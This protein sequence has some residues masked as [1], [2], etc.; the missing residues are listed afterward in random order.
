MTR[1]LCMP[2]VA[3]TVISPQILGAVES[4]IVNNQY[5]MIQIGFNVN[6]VEKEGVDA[7]LEHNMIIGTSKRQNSAYCH[8][9]KT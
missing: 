4:R 3:K 9:P 1:K 5:Q 6:F 7:N 8:G 2:T